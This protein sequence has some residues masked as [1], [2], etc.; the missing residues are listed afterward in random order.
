MESAQSISDLAGS[1]SINEQ[2]GRHQTTRINLEQQEVEA[3]N[4]QHRTRK[5]V[6]DSKM[7]GSFELRPGS[8]ESTGRVQREQEKAQ[9]I[10]L[11]YGT[12]KSISD[13]KESDMV[14]E[15]ESAF[16]KCS[17]FLELKRDERENCELQKA[18]ELSLKQF[19]RCRTIRSTR[20][21]LE[22]RQL[23]RATKASIADFERHQSRNGD[24]QPPVLRPI[25]RTPSKRKENGVQLF[26]TWSKRNSLTRQ[27][28]LIDDFRRRLATELGRLYFDDGDVLVFLQPS[29][30]SR[31]RYGVA[32][33]TFDSSKTFRI[34]SAKLFSTG[35]TYFRDLLSPTKQFRTTRR[36]KCLPL[37]PGIKYVLDLTPPQEGD[38]AVN[39]IT[40]LS[41]S[42]GVR[43]W[44][45]AAERWGVPNYL[46]A[47]QD[48][49]ETPLSFCSSIQQGVGQAQSPLDTSQ[50]P[51]GGSEDKTFLGPQRGER[52]LP[53]ASSQHQAEK[54]WERT[55][56]STNVSMEEG[57]KPV[58][59]PEDYTSTRHCSA[60]QRVLHAI[61][62][63]DAKID[64]A[65]KL[66]S[67]FVIAKYFDCAAVVEDHI[68]SWVYGGPNTRFI[69][70]LPEVSSKL[71][72]GLQN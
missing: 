55:K 69:E 27:D 20:Q 47:G 45:Y 66:W 7:T 17:R 41:C 23:E 10:G 2:L 28:S 8:H 57:T 9:G 49:V 56:S 39:L 22:T 16:R 62:G 65:P 71:A 4:F 3:N 35:S 53:M 11:Q 34:H 30:T 19:E 44:F 43:K 67:F 31:D 58:H 42:E 63:L 64:S 52:A 60:I 26:P 33:T 18:T 61:E 25:D 59:I 36:L 48:V 6:I 15:E 1:K 37:P 54:Y 68:I 51:Q 46:V 13:S 38:V 32:Y 14:E 29:S 5:S 70:I 21:A 24:E 50:T 12:A 72:D 40:E